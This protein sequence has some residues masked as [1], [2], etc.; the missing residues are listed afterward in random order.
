MGR[1]TKDKRLE[2]NIPAVNSA[3]RIAYPRAG[4]ANFRSF[5]PSGE[6]SPHAWSTARPRENFFSGTVAPYRREKIRRRTQDRPAAVPCVQKVVQDRDA[7]RP[8]FP[9]VLR[10]REKMS[11]SGPSSTFNVRANAQ[12]FSNRCGKS[13][14]LPYKGRGYPGRRA[15]AW[16]LPRTQHAHARETS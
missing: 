2:L 10:S 4:P 11:A 7:R 13:A 16:R 1:E 15:H 14:P 6:L 3:P 5:R 12:M 9:A 8:V